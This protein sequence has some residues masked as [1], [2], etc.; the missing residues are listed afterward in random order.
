M[1][2]W[3]SLQTNR[4]IVFREGTLV[5]L[6]ISDA[7]LRDLIVERFF[8]KLRPLSHPLSSISFIAASEMYF[9][10]V[11]KEGATAVP[12]RHQSN[13]V[14]LLECI[15]VVCLQIKTFQAI[16]LDSN[17]HLLMIKERLLHLRTAWVLPAPVFAPSLASYSPRTPTFACMTWHV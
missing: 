4:W 16:L 3:A 5:V 2:T 9:Q 15:L 6:A 13:L 7:P 11:R 14:I 10:A 17:N 1:Q 8:R 12:T